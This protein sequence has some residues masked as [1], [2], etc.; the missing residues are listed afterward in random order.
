M[1]RHRHGSRNGEW[2]WRVAE[3]RMQP[4]ILE[5]IADFGE[6]E[7]LRGERRRATQVL[8]HELGSSDSDLCSAFAHIE[9]HVAEGLTLTASAC[10]AGVTRRTLGAWVKLADDRRA[11]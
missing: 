7:R 3:P 10:L 2:G 9:Q 4:D 8:G 1:S 6:L 5:A 11:P